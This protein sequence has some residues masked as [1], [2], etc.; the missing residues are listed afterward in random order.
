M[1]SNEIEYKGLHYSTLVALYDRRGKGAM[2]EGPQRTWE[3]KCIV[4]HI[5]IYVGTTCAL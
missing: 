3:A 4:S 2:D 5:L 1:L